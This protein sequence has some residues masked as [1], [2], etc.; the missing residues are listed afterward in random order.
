[1]ILLVGAFLVFFFFYLNLPNVD[2][3]KYCCSSTKLQTTNTCLISKELAVRSSSS[4]I[5]VLFSLCSWR[6]H[7]DWKER[8]CLEQLCILLTMR[9]LVVHINVTGFLVLFFTI[10]FCVHVYMGQFFT[11]LPDSYP[12]QVRS[13]RLSFLLIIVF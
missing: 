13:S 8:G 9:N 4:W 5:S 2:L 12:L 6:H 7:N 1:M 10:I 11:S 3:G